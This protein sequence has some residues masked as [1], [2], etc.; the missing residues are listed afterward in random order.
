[1]TTLGE[2]FIEVHADTKPFARELATELKTILAEVDKKLQPR[3]ERLGENISKKIGDGVDK[4]S[5]TIRRFTKKIGDL[6][7]REGKSWTRKLAA[8]FEKMAK[9][10]FILTRIFGQMVL[11]VGRFTRSIFRLSMGVLDFVG[12]LGQ[13]VFALAQVLFTG[14]KVLVG[15]GGDLA[16]AMSNLGK[17]AQMAVLSL[18]E[19]GAQ[20][21]AMSP[22]IIAVIAMIWLLIAAFAALVAILTVALAPFATLIGFLVG[23]P[24]IVTGAVV[25]ILPLIIALHGIT[26]AFAALQEKDPKK[27][28]E[29]L[30]ALSPV[31][32]MLVRAVK[33][34]LPLLAS[35]RDNIQAAFLGPILT[36][37]QP[38]LRTVIPQLGV[39]L[40]AIATSLGN[41]ALSIMRLLMSQEALDGMNEIMGQIALFLDENTGSILALIRALGQTA[42][43]ML[44][45][46]LSMFR[47]FSGFLL[48]FSKWVQDAIADGR[49]QRWW[50]TAK[51]SAKKIWDLILALIDLFKEMF[52]QT[53][54][55]GRKFL[56]KITDA[57]RKFTEWLRSP[58]GKKALENAVGLANAFA[59]AF[60]IAL[61]IIKD[62]LN[63]VNA[64]VEAIKW[65]NKN[66]PGGNKGAKKEISSPTG[67]HVGH[68][69]FSG[70]G[71]VPA[72]ELAM[73]H[74]GEPILDPSNSVAR[75][76][77]ILA[78]AGM[79]DVLAERGSTVVN[80]Y[81]G[82]QRLDERVDYRIAKSNSV[83][84]RSL[85]TGTRST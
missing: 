9:G 68:H 31:M 15:L 49:F 25:T 26:D 62:A 2:A 85:S 7:D 82:T 52:S 59:D 12:V 36:K 38:F 14:V 80:V 57:I 41:I 81:L 10:N 60:R 83:M 74:R 44:P 55:G 6:F 13:L 70:G 42:V 3:S 19:F 30:K 1:V 50:D 69:S 4:Q 11:A 16:G 8:P 54:E 34:V 21:V 75:N 77:Q 33:P 51:E 63:T 71:V 61:D 24:T 47:T 67:K 76:R 40:Q 18:A 84:A 64:I 22:S 20:V 17:F 73:V 72:D 35:V 39:G 29:K 46:V 45:A 43:A 5:P 58:E 48:S 27:Y 78:N 65:I 66:T 23:L 79:L 56:Q 53:D 32:R 37:L 28:A